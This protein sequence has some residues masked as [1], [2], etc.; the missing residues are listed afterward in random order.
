MDAEIWLSLSVFDKNAGST[1]KMKALLSV[2]RPEPSNA[3]ACNSPQRLPVARASKK[4]TLAVTLPMEAVLKGSNGAFRKA[5]S[6]IER[7]HL[8]TKFNGFGLSN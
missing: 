6:T 3:R 7:S 2:L 1:R 4:K 5:A 8:G